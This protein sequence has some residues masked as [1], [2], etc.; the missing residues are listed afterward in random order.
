MKPRISGRQYLLSFRRG[1]KACRLVSVLAAPGSGD[2]SGAIALKMHELKRPYHLYSIRGGP[3]ATRFLF[4]PTVHYGAQCIRAYCTQYRGTFKSTACA[5]CAK[6]THQ[7]TPCQDLRVK[8]A[9]R[10]ISG[11]VQ[12]GRTRG[13]GRGAGARCR[14]YHSPG[15]WPLPATARATLPRE[16]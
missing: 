7:M 2:D 3:A 5:N 8:W 16:Y 15:D 9:C 13:L 11:V 12:I 14:P 4:L 10:L 1:S 6:P